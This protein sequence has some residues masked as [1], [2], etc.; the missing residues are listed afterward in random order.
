MPIQAFGEDTL[1]YSFAT[2]A[3]FPKG[4]IH[5]KIVPFFK[6]EIKYLLYFVFYLNLL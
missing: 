2:S 6:A 4:H 1:S 3:G 5:S